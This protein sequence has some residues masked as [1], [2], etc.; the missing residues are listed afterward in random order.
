M[1]RHIAAIAVLALAACEGPRHD[2][3]P[4]RYEAPGPE[5]HHLSVDVRTG[6]GESDG[7]D[8][9]AVE[10]CLTAEYCLPIDFA[11]ADVL[12]PGRT[13]VLHVD[14]LPVPAASFDRVVLRSKGSPDAWV[15]ACI[16]V[17]IDGEVIH[18][19]DQLDVVIGDAGDGGVATWTDPRGI[20][21]ACSSCAE[22][23]VTHGPVVG[24]VTPDAARL[25]LRTD[26]A[27][28]V[29]A[30][31]HDEAD[32]TAPVTRVDVR[33]RADD[34]F[35]A[36]FDVPGLAPG[37]RYRAFFEAEGELTPA[38]ATFHTPPAPG[39]KGTLK[40]AFGSCARI[41]PQSIFDVAAREAPDFFVFGG[42]NTYA[43][44]PK[45]DVHWAHLRAALEHRARADFLKT[46]PSIAI[47]DD[48]DFTGN[49]SNGTWKGKGEVLRAFE[50]YFANTSLGTPE[51]PG[52]FSTF[53]W[54]D[55]E[56][57][58]LDVRSYRSPDEEFDGT[59]LGEAQ[60]KWLEE[61][62]R[63]SQATFKLL[64]SGSVWGPSAGETWLDHPEARERLFDF[65]SYQ[66]IP[67]I[68]LLGG[69]LHRSMLR[70]NARPEA[71][72]LPE[73]VSSPLAVPGT[74]K[75]PPPERGED[76]ITC[77][78]GGNAVAVLAFDTARPDPSLEVRLLDEGSKEVGKMEILRSQLQ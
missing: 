41:P 43:D 65:L 66:R 55:V 52:V 49:D 1:S 74:W 56:L 30:L 75:C 16:D 4:R 70:R 27:R 69:D 44:S 36:I 6:D 20:H 38:S 64:V 25:W 63:L 53:Q 72:T 10:I 14:A 12:R 58:L 62:L 28:D 35:T 78:D 21:L 32:A 40:L 50:D 23:P 22:E 57:F 24:A 77:F 33:T 18:C 46:T 31:V 39:T 71:Y 13:D 19:E 76:R 26:L 29:T 45:T 48:H 37:H 7:A 17:A 15:P 5:V 67:G 47:W 60:E 34:D 68:V 59:M 54:G 3:T 51:T 2:A 11:N 9:H 42:D 61:R 73:I 8:R